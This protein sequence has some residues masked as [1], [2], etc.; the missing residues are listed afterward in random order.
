MI[1]PRSKHWVLV[2]N[3]GQAR[4]LELRRKPYEFRQV[5]EIFSETRRTP[6][7]DMV[8]DGSG[9]S[10]HVQGPGSHAKQQR[11]DPHEQAE[12][13][14]TRKLAVNLDKAAGQGRFE[15]LAIIADPRTM[16]RMRRYMS[17]PLST[18]VAQELTIDL[19]GL[20]LQELEPR[21]RKAL[22]WAA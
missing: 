2:A 9:R 4:V 19:A 16:G 20:P 14:F 8:S 15:H 13:Q 7:R 1:N 17:K 3:G 21:V 11:S 5:A 22:G 12:E 18:R 6:S 10:Y